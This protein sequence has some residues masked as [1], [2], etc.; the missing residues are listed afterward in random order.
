[1]KAIVHRQAHE[2]FPNHL[3][4]LAPKYLPAIPRDPFTG[5]PFQYTASP[6]GSTITSAGHFPSGLLGPQRP[7]SGH[8]MIV[9]LGIAHN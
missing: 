4:Q 1:M 5:K 6:I 8:A 9:H 7:F 3:A 2:V